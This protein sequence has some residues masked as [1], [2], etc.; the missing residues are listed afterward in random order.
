[1][2]SFNYTITNHPAS[3]SC[4]IKLTGHLTAANA[5]H[6]KEQMCKHMDVFGSS[7]TLDLTEL[8]DLDLTGLNALLISKRTFSRSGKKI[9]CSFENNSAVNRYIKLTKFEK[10]LNAA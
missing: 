5:I 8:E 10:F 1:M 3:I 4:R 2:K 9:H 6:F 7:L